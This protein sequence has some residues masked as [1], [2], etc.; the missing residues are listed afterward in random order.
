MQIIRSMVFLKKLCKPQISF[1]YL[2]T[3]DQIYTKYSVG[4]SAVVTG[5]SKGIGLECVKTL[6]KNGVMVSY[7]YCK[8][9]NYITFYFY[10]FAKNFRR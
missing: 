3:C 2:S 8:Y 10:M 1:K 5:C 4:K 6:L 7:R 9:L